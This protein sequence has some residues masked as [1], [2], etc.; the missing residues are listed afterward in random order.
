MGA[1]SEE[2]LQV[3]MRLGNDPGLDSSPYPGAIQSVIHVC[4]GVSLRPWFPLPC[5]LTGKCLYQQKTKER[6]VTR[7]GPVSE[8]RGVQNTHRAVQSAC[9]CPAD[10]DLREGGSDVSKSR[11]S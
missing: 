7:G 4:A 3:R 1:A 8:H 9:E 5:Y 6:G 10:T 2:D 11:F